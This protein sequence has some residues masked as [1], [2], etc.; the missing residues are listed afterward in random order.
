MLRSMIEYAKLSASSI[1]GKI[2]GGAIVVV[3]FIFASS[4]GLAALYMWLRNSYGDVMAAVILAVG[5]AVI[6]I[7][8]AFVVMARIRRQEQLLE[9]IRAEAK[10]SAFSTAL[11]AVNPALMLGAG[12]IAIGLFR[13]APVLT[14]VAP[15]AAGFLLAMASAR[16]RRRASAVDPIRASGRSS[17]PRTSRELVH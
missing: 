6:G 14:A 5:F 1:A 4:F 8:A 3:P 16:Q 9:E 11:L 15:L 13:R 17:S 12:R 7:I 2:V 10:Q